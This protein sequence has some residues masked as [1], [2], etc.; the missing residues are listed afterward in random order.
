M[1]ASIIKAPAAVLQYIDQV[2]HLAD[3]NRT[4]FGFLPASAYAEAAMKGC[5]WVAI[6][7]ATK[8]LRGYLFFGGRYPR[9]KVF[10]IYACP[11]HRSSGM[12]RQ[13]IRELKTYG[14]GHDYLSIAARV[15]SE[16]KANEFWKKNGFDII[17]RTPG[18][19][20]GRTINHYTLHLDV[21]SLLPGGQRHITSPLDDAEQIRYSR[22]LLP[23]LSY[24]L[25]LNVFFD[26]VRS[27]DVGESAHL[28][29][30]ALDNEIRL[31][32]T[33]EF[34]KELERHSRDLQNDPVL[35][36]A[37]RLPTLPE[38]RPEI[39]T[40]LTDE[41]RKLLAPGQPKTGKR[42]ANDASDLI[43]LA[44]CI[45][46]KAY[47]FVTRDGAILQR[48]TALR[49]QYGLR[50]ISPV[51]LT[52]SFND[53]DSHYESRSATVEHEDIEVAT[54]NEQSRAD[55]ERFLDNLGVESNRM[56]SCLEPGSMRRP[57][58]R[59][60]V[61]TK[62]QIIGICSWTAIRPSGRETTLHLYV[63][64]DHPNSER[65]IDCL[66]ESSMAIGCHGQLY[67]LH[68]KISPRQTKT[69]EV[70]IQR[71]FRP[72]D[73]RDG[74]SSNT[75]SKMSLRGIITT[76]DWPR[77]RSEFRETTGLMLQDSMPRHTTSSDAR[78]TLTSVEHHSSRTISL[79]DFETLIAPGALLYLNRSAVMVPIREEYANGLLPATGSQP[80]FLPGSEA[81]LRLER[82]YFWA[83]GKHAL[84]QRG[85]IVV[86]YVSRRRR[87]AV[88]L[89]RV[90]FSDSLTKTQAVMNLGRQGVLTEQEIHQRA[91]N[92]N[93]VAAFTFD[94]L[95]VFREKIAFRELKRMGCIGGAN[96]V[97][98]Q[99]LTH[100][101]M[102]KI[103]KRAF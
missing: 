49:L 18:G 53:T 5:L 65:A 30:L 25:D 47:G 22:P 43:H 42:A 33:S 78:I 2:R 58:S 77:F 51:D 84:V 41:L 45:H 16:L 96:L 23:T 37:R 94:N 24:V 17:R 21:P 35:A 13:L 89:A 72:S 70:A 60:V 87:E 90:T 54:L 81:V 14:E 93:E 101:S 26:I 3:V 100:E 92:R 97:T 80:S 10:Q 46:H 50:I 91:N 74:M 64:E 76:G 82:A 1:T 86:F 61:Q 59:V 99:P 98:A 52:N 63:D 19:A 67:R 11:E 48:A 9:L 103:V 88:A 4:A 102:L 27:R 66:L 56:S 79:F 71:G 68:L 44:S 32:T 40:P 6:D 39:L 36:F 20:T 62:Q 57:R 7:T 15:A 69:R 83:A 8:Q 75:L 29:S 95:L 12:G 31:S 38:L 85:M 28:L 73:P 34:A 55:V